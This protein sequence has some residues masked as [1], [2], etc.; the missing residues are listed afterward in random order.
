MT[1]K[2]VTQSSPGTHVPSIKLKGNALKQRLS[3]LEKKF[4]ESMKELRIE[5]DTARECIETFC[6]EVNIPSKSKANN[7]TEMTKECK[8]LQECL[9]KIAKHYA[10]SVTELKA[11]INSLK[12][13]VTTL[14]I[15]EGNNET[16]SGKG[17][18]I[19]SNSLSF[20][21]NL[22]S[23]LESLRPS[24]TTKRCVK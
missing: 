7:Q 8:R 11:E 4:E 20:K 15:E 2:N 6:T 1:D 23:V 3:V 21:R 5:I 12:L 9:S 17:A 16:N 24:V 14:R 10:D 22:T 19:D 18:C 13:E